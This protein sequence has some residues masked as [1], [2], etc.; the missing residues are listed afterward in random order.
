M[1]SPRT[2]KSNGQIALSFPDV[3]R[4]Q[5]GKQAFDAAQ[6]LA[7]LRKRANVLADFG[8]GAVVRTQARNEM[9]IGK[10]AHVKDE[11]RIRRN[12][13]AIAETD[14]GHEQRAR[15]GILEAGSDK[16][17]KLV[18]VELR[19]ID[20]HIGELADGLHQG[21]LMAQALA[22]RIILSE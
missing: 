7:G 16:V 5:I 6:K 22:H 8:V 20:D 1:L 2:A 9:W 3:M 13:V 15:L 4:N 12:T 14:H 11:I 10:K 19:G 18:H 21:A 17:A